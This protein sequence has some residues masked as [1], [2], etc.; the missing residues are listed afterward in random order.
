MAD[1]LPVPNV[2]SPEY[3]HD[4]AT[5]TS[6]ASSFVPIE[7]QDAIQVIDE[8]KAFNRSI[9]DYLRTR[10]SG[11]YRIVSVFGSQSTGK[12]TLLNHLF[13]TNFDVMDE[14]NRQQTTKGI[15][16]AH[17]PGV[18]HHGAISS[19]ENILV[20]DVEGTDGRERGE[21][22][23]FERKAALFALA[24]SEVLIVNL[25]ETQVGLYQ[26]A[27]MGLLKTVFEV[28]LSLFGRAKAHNN[29]HKVLLLFVIRDHV[30]VTPQSSLAATI[31]QDLLQ[32]WDS[33]N[34]PAEV[35]HLRFHDF[36]DLAFHTLGHKVLQPDKFAADIRLLGNRFADSS[37]E[38]FLFKPCYHHDIPLDGWPMYAES[39]WAQID[40]NKDLDLPTQQILVAKFKCDEIAAQCFDEFDARHVELEKAAVEATA[41][42]NVDCKEVGLTLADLRDEALE[43]YDLLASKYNPSVYEQKRETLAARINAKLLDVFAVYS[44]HLLAASVRVFSA[45]LSK[46]PRSGT[47]VETVQALTVSV[48][49]E[50]AAQLALL[51]LQGDLD[52]RPYL[53]NLQESVELIV[54]KQQT[55]ELNALVGKF[56]KKLNNGLSTT[57]LDEI[58]GPSDHTWNHILQKFH[59]LSAA[60]LSK[61]QSGEHFDFALGT[62]PQLNDAAVRTFEFRS[63]DLLSDLIHKYISKDNLLSILKERFDDKFR[64]DENGLPKLYQNTRE[65]EGYFGEAKTH[66][67]KVFPILTFAK[68]FD[69]TEL[70]PKYDVRS[71]ALKKR[72]ETV[73]VHTEEEEY[74]EDSDDDEGDQCFAEIVSEKEKAEILSKFKREADA[75][76]VETKRSIMQLVTQIPYYIYLIIVVLGW[77]EFMA[78]VRNPFFF[79][80]LIVLGAGFYVMFQL[81]LLGPAYLVMQRMVDEAVVVAKQKLREFVVD[82]HEQHGRNLGK[83]GNKPEEIELDDLSPEE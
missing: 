64:Y 8:K 80:L 24:T 5:R 33:L 73:A 43:N 40:S 15:W 68:M 18:S 31:S 51:S 61:Y 53:E 65:L 60:A 66:A 21:D 42:G 38:K 55:A 34:R 81:N 82:E 59:D 72:Y 32:I 70:V 3:D 28:N 56:L 49:D 74:V 6:S 67:M 4:E 78:I 19:E 25:W 14:V 36:F 83:M 2:E 48:L 11:D 1:E 58:A 63:W 71:R 22:Q 50:F 30:G 23:D 46:K 16:L 54:S 75:K 35:A 17:S 79:T 29:D 7:I 44:K 9:L 77:N 41:S 76:F 12:S 52:S 37:D 27:N 62:D 69:G 57:I 26:G 45:G 13:N 10:G 47:F 39:C 20:M